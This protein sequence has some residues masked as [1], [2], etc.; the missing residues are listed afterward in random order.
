MSPATE[1]GEPRLGDFLLT[2][3]DELLAAWNAELD[4]RGVR[5]TAFRDAA[6]GLLDRLAAVLR[7]PREPTSPP[8]DLSGLPP[9]DA[10][11]VVEPGAG[12]HAMALLVSIAVHAWRDAGGACREDEEAFHAAA[13]E[14]MVWSV[15][16]GVEE[17]VVSARRDVEEALIARERE[18]ER[19]FAL[20]PDMILVVGRDG[21]I[22]RANPALAAAVGI[23][24]AELIGAQ[25]LDLVHP[26]DRDAARAKLEGAFAGPSAVRFSFRLVRG[27]GHVRWASFDASADPGADE[28]V[29]VGRDVTEERGRTELEQQLIGIVSHDL[30]NPL[31]AIAMATQALLHR[32]DLDPRTRATAKRIAAAVGR[33]AALIKD[34]LDFTRARRPGGIPIAPVPLDLHAAVRAAVDELRPG[35]AG[36]EIRVESSGDGAGSW[37]PARLEQLVQN[38]VSNALKYGAPDRPVGVRTLGGD[39]WVRIEVWNA[40]DPIHPDLLPH[41][42]EPL[43][44]AARTGGVGGVRGVG[45]GLYIVDHIARAHGGTVDVVSSA[46][47]GTTFVVRLPREPPMA[48]GDG[49][50]L[51]RDGVGV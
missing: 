4:A 6:P 5:L 8:A 20:S 48:E 39:L 3:R 34:L 14:V 29:A 30:R 45:L 46:Q 26:E 35:A 36:R 50:G 28:V 7:E 43:R 1:A 13:D 49:L 31:N 12:A 10:F 9:I 21:T 24:I 16:R 32:S 18:L 15:F 47:A 42:F 38:L 25:H 37:D 44:Q 17:R 11:A 23:P 27:D 2:R 51:H 22:R 19:L 41:V 40:G 33:G